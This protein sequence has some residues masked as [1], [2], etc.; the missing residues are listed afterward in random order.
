MQFSKF[1][2][3]LYLEI[4]KIMESESPLKATEYEGGIRAGYF[5]LGS[6]DDPINLVF[7]FPLENDDCYFTLTDGEVSEVTKENSINPRIQ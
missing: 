5:V 7:S 4:A 3:S 2:S 6:D 1:E